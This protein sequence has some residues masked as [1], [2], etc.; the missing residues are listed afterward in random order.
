MRRLLFPIRLEPVKPAAGR[1]Y[2]VARTAL[3]VLALLDDPESDDS[4]DSGAK[5]LRWWTHSQRL[6]TLAQM[7]LEVELRGPVKTPIF[8]VIAQ[9]KFTNHKLNQL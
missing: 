7:P 6:R 1:P 9:P 3:D 5:S 4:W 2:F 8:R